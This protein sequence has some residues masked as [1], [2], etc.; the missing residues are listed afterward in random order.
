MVSEFG[1]EVEVLG[2]LAVQRPLSSVQGYRSSLGQLGSV[3]VALC[4][5]LVVTC[6]KCL[7]KLHPARK[8]L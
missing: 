3:H 1:E 7:L 8:G 4:L 2:F 5:C 6:A